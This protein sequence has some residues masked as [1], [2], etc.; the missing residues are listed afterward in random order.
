MKDKN[1]YSIFNLSNFPTFTAFISKSL[2]LGNAFEKW[3][4]SVLAITIFGIGPKAFKLFFLIKQA[5]VMNMHHESILN[6]IILGFYWA[7]RQ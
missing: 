2:K 5:L 6:L 1:Y 4:S 3:S 7:F